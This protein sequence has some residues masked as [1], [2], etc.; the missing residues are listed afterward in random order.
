[1]KERAPQVS[2]NQKRITWDSSQSRNTTQIHIPVSGAH[3]QAICRIQARM[4]LLHRDCFKH[5]R[6]CISAWM[7]IKASISASSKT[8][9]ILR[10]V[11]GRSICKN[12]IL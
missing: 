5:N 12:V 2:I 8:G 6:D 10:L 3:H 4:I 9:H 11:G 7:L 1:M